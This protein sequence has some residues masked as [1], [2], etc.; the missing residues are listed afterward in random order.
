L[1]APGVRVTFPMAT[2]AAEASFAV[3]EP[4]D[5]TVARRYIT[6][7]FSWNVITDQPATVL[8]EWRSDRQPR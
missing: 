1:V 7:E 3:V 2:H 4:L 6:L 8:G 5:P